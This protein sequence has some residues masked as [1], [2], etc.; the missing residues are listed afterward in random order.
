[1]ENR[2]HLLG[3]N[4]DPLTM[5]KTLLRIEQLI[6]EKKPSQ[7][8][9]INASKINLMMENEEL[10]AIV[11]NSPLVN[12]DGQSVVW[13]A[14]FL[15]YEVPER[16]TGIDLFEKLVAL[17]ASKG[18]RPYYFGATEDVVQHVVKKHQQAY[19]ELDVAGYRNGYFDDAESVQIEKEIRESHAD[20][21]FVAFSSPQKELWVNAHKETM[22]V[23]FVMGV[24]GSFDVIA[25]KTKRAPRW[26]QKTG[27][28]WFFRLIQEPKRMFKRYLIGNYRFIRHVFQEK[29]KRSV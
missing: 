25:G 28:E 7:H 13:A 24:G 27:L 12:A 6:L 4:L 23:P 8:V 21:L 16:V 11:N 10:R 29:R 1:M 20:I 15:G 17:A 2:I 26:M 3:S 22:Q 9:V 19:P 14:R 18:F 5:E